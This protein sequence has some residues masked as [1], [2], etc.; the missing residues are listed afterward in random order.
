MCVPVCVCHVR[1]CVTCVCVCHVRV[2]MCVRV[3]Q[4]VRVCVSVCVCVCVCVCSVCVCVC[5]VCVC[6]GGGGGGG[7]GTAAFSVLRGTKRVRICRFLQVLLKRNHEEGLSLSAKLWT[8]VTVVPKAVLLRKSQCHQKPRV[9][10]SVSHKA[11][12]CVSS[13]NP[14]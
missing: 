14:E 8:E 6:A 12:L 1:V 13:G 5:S 2:C 4:C 10:G 3:C 11:A 9:I 7:G